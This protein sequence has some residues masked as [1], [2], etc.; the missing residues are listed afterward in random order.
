MYQIQVDVERAICSV[1]CPAELRSWLA[2]KE[3]A[4][5]EEK[6]RNLKEGSLD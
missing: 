3:A 1:V 5:R 2:A 6:K 4:N